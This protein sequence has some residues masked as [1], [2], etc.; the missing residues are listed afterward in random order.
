[1]RSQ[2]VD[3]FN[4]TAM[5]KS[6]ILSNLRKFTSFDEHDRLANIQRRVHGLTLQPSR[7][8]QNCGESSS[9]PLGKSV[10][11]KTHGSFKNREMRSFIQFFRKYYAK[12]LWPTMLGA[13]FIKFPTSQRKSR[14][15]ANFEFG[16]SYL[17][18]R[19]T[20]WPRNKFN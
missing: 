8:S 19:R 20:Y 5:K 9:N 12:N 17:F 16:S 11:H 14:R 10:K 3:R 13:S 4:D 15:F 2:S 18:I 1:M 6:E 7:E